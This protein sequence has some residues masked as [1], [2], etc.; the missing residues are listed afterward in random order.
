MIWWIVG[1]AI[2]MT[3]VFV[4]VKRHLGEKILISL[5]WPIVFLTTLCLG[6]VTLLMRGDEKYKLEN[7]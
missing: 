4:L 6:L 7:I 2:V 5:F 1:Y 3:V